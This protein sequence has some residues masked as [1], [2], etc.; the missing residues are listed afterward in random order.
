MTEL[1]SK[2]LI[3][4]GVAA[5]VGTLLLILLLVG[6]VPLLPQEQ[7]GVCE[8]CPPPGPTFVA[9]NPSAGTCPSGGMFD[10]RGCVAGDF[11]YTLTIETSTVTFGDVR[12]HI[13]TAN[14]AIYVATG[15]HSGFS[16]LNS[17][18]SVVADYQTRG[19]PMNMTLTWSYTAGT[20]AAVPLTSLYTIDLDMGTTNPHGQGY[21]F[22]GV[23][24]GR[25][26]ETT[27]LPL[28]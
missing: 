23:V 20:N 27:V 26:P 9:G 7:V 5:T 2:S 4:V 24:S 3:W 28:P 21:S 1:P 11:V 18:G 25:I 8:G 15:A 6:V 10:A 17:S 13:E 14:D 22:I 16:I 12:F 19:G